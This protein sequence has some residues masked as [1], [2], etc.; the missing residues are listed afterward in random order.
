MRNLGIVDIDFLD[1][2]GRVDE[3]KHLGGG[4][5]DASRYARKNGLGTGDGASEQEAYF[6]HNRLNTS[7]ARC[8]LLTVFL[9]K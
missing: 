2:R 3:D 9:E 7:E 5:V 4:K 1:E 6:V 8:K